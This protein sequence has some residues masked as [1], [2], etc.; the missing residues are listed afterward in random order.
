[1]KIAIIPARGNSKGIKRKNLVDLG[2]KPLL[3]WSI[4]PALKVFDHVFVSTEDDEI[5]EYAK[6]YCNVIKR[7]PKL[8]EDH[9][10]ATEVVL[11]FLQDNKH[12]QYDKIF[13]LQVTSPYRSENSLRQALTLNETNGSVAGVSYLTKWNTVRELKDNYMANP[14]D[15]MGKS[16]NTQ[17]QQMKELYRINGAIFG[18]WAC[19]L[20]VHKSFLNFDTVPLI[21]DYKESLEIDTHED[22]DL[23]RYMF[24]YKNV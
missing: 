13:L 20:E 22:L 21:M 24:G 5:A 17:R 12:H 10:T 16:K 2:G 23:A 14:L 8:S 1:M 7:D 6:Q 15:V 19:M 3:Y 9:V 4:E 18:A 11:S